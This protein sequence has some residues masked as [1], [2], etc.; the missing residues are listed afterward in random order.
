MIEDMFDEYC[1]TPTAVF[2]VGHMAKRYTSAEEFLLRRIKE[3]PF[4]HVDETR[5]N[6]QGTEHYVWVFTDGTHVIFRLTNTRETTI[7]QEVLDGYSG[8]LVTD[9]YAGYD[10]VTCRQQKCLVHLIRDIN[11]ELWN[12]PF[13]TDLETLASKVKEL[14][15]PILTDVE[16]YGL[17]KR[18]LQKYQKAVEGFYKHVIEG[19]EWNSEVM[20][21]FITR[22]RR[23]KESL[24]VFLTE[25]AIPWNNNTGERAIRHLAVQRKISGTFYKSFASHHLVLLGIAQTCRFQEKSFLKFLLSG[26]MNVDDFHPKKRWRVTRLLRGSF[27]EGQSNKR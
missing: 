21:R 16:R 25:D 2:F 10:A 23:Y 18:H 19:T 6:I 5:I 7:V 12:N 22:F 3:G 26:E 13:D 24:F 1:S 8:V 15:L 17:R 4:V 9:F 11:N 27:A 14:L 20:H